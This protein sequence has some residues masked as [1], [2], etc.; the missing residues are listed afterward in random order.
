MHPAY[1]HVISYIHLH[2]FGI[3]TPTSS[4]SHVIMY[5]AS[6]IHS[7][8]PMIICIA[9]VT[10][11]IPCNQVMHFTCHHVSCIMH[12]SILA[13]DHLY[14]QS[15]KKTWSFVKNKCC[16]DR[17]GKKRKKK[18]MLIH[19]FIHSFPLHEKWKQLHLI[20]HFQDKIKLI[21]LL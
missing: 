20:L 16:H 12:T 21:N 3:F 5:L 1:A 4:I 9:F 15:N 7:Y 6:C 19:L 18:S 10:W 14:T 13:H 8:Q 17:P 11:C 2:V